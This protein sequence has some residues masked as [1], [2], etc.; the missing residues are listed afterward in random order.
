M[1]KKQKHPFEQNR[2][3]II[4]CV[5][6]CL[7]VALP[8]WAT[9]S[10]FSPSAFEVPPLPAPPG[11]VDAEADKDKKTDQAAAPTSPEAGLPE[12]VAKLNALPAIEGD[13][14]D[15]DKKD[16][17]TEVKKDNFGKPVETEPKEALADLPPPL[18]ESSEG[19][20]S[21]LDLSKAPPPLPEVTEL[22]P[23]VLNLPIPTISKDEE[24]ITELPEITVPA[25]KPK[26]KT[27]RTTLAPAI[28]PQETNFHYRRE[29]LPATIY[30]HEYAEP[31]K[32]LP[33]AMHREDYANQLFESVVRNDVQTTR[34]LLNAGTPVNVVASNGETPLATAL[35]AGSTAT[36]Q[37]LIARG[38]Y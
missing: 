27:W 19:T 26:G 3:T 28:I 12:D 29:L 8:V 15:A 34:A 18:P 7:G 25:V 14:K 30:R 11:A 5:A 32:H 21:V 4:A 9:T 1:I 23:P 2:K 24:K 6:I 38:G 17:E 10:N 37:L 16:K 31:N 13:K 35:R 22:K 36:A 33:L 20:S